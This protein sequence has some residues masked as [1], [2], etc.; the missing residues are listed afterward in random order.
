MFHWISFES[1]LKIDWAHRRGPTVSHPTEGLGASG[2]MTPTLPVSGTLLLNSGS[3]SSSTCSMCLKI[4]G[5][6]LL[7][8]PLKTQ[9]LESIADFHETYCWGLDVNCTESQF[10][11]MSRLPIYEQRIS[12]HLLKSPWIL[13]LM[14]CTFQDT[15]IAHILFRFLLISCFFL[16][17]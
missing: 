2:F 15:D 8:L 10:G 1:F 7:F 14:F 12:L 5:L 4:L 13:S 11:K 3:I 6:S 16:L 9:I 17:L